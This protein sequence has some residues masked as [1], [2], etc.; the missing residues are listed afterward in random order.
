MFS[1]LFAHGNYYLPQVISKQ[2]PKSSAYRTLGALDGVMG[3]RIR[4]QDRDHIGCGLFSWQDSAGA[5]I[6]L[7]HCYQTQ[8]QAKEVL[9]LLCL[10]ALLMTLMNRWT[11]AVNGAEGHKPVGDLLTT[12]REAGLSDS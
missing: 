4:H 5:D 10:K 8:V 2:E 1:L 7:L 11:N 12:R 6:I 9:A 3:K